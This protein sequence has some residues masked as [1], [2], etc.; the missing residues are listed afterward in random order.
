MKAEYINPFLNAAIKVLGTMAAT[1]VTPGKPHI[2]EGNKTWGIVSGIIGLAGQQITG[3][4]VISFDKPSILGIVSRML[5]E[6][7]ADITPDVIDAVGEITN[8][9]SGGAKA[10]LSEQGFQFEMA[11]PIMMVGEGLE[12]TQLTKEPVISLDFITQ[13]GKFVIE[14]CLMEIAKKH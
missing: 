3:N 6:T 12:I 1:K 8:M 14:A 13:E 10:A 5:M 4:M 2:K 11:T 7:Y 9:I